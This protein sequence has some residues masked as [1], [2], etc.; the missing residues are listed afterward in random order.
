[1]NATIINIELG[2]EIFFSRAVREMVLPLQNQEMGNE[3]RDEGQLAQLPFLMQV[4]VPS[5]FL[6]ASKGAIILA[7]GIKL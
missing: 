6:V 2:K 3:L 5:P 1:M 7:P 4:G